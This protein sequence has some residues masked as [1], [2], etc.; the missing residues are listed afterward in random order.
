MITDYV[1]AGYPAL[2]VRTHEQERFISKSSV[3]SECHAA[4]DRERRLRKAS[5]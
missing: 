5:L 3:C 4:K 2:L 1:K